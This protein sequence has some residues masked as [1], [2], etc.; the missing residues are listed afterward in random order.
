MDFNLNLI[1]PSD[2]VAYD[3]LQVPWTAVKDKLPDAV[4]IY[5]SPNKDIAVILTRNKILVYDIVN[6]TLSDAPLAGYKLEDGSSVIMA[7]WG[8]GEYAPIWEKSFTKNNVTKQVEAI[9]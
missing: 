6:K 9:K 5:T 3:A 8:I 1:P 2:M 7:E 4:D